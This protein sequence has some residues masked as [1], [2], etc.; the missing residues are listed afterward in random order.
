MPSKVV[1]RRSQQ[2]KILW[3]FH[4]VLDHVGDDAAGREEFV[5][6]ILS[7]MD[8]PPSE[9]E[10]VVGLLCDTLPTDLHRVN[11]AEILKAFEQALPIEWEEDLYRVDGAKSAAFKNAVLAIL[12]VRTPE[13]LPKQVTALVIAELTR[14]VGSE[15]QEELL[16]AA[17]AALEELFIRELWRSKD[18]AAQERLTSSVVYDLKDTAQLVFTDS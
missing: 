1:L 11:T 14:V 15:V 3:H 5:R 16:P 13:Q 2:D 7:E 8:V 12:A 10:R 18:L 9:L 4:V 6:E 17:T